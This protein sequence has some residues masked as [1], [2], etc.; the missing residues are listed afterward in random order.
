MAKQPQGLT[1][2]KAHNRISAANLSLM[3]QRL[4]RCGDINELSGHV[5]VTQPHDDDVEHMAV[6]IGGPRDG[7]V[8]ATWGGKKANTFMPQTLPDPEVPNA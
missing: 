8:Y 1:P 7:Y 2:R 5:C 3:A 4:G 6:Q